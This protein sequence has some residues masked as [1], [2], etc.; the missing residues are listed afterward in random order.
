MI[1]VNLRPGGKK[2]SPRG[3]RLAISFPKFEK[4]PQDPWVLA[5]IASGVAVV[6]IAAWLFLSLGG[7]RD[8]VQVA[9]DQALADSARYHEQ[10]ERT[11]TLMASRDSIVQR[12]AIIQEIDKGRYVWP[13]VVDEVSRALPD[14]TWI[15]ELAQITGGPEP[16]VRIL[17][18]SG[19]I[20]AFSVFMDQLEASPFLRNVTT[21]GTTEVREQN[22]L[23]FRYELEVTYEQPPIE[24]LQ[25]EPLLTT[26]GS[27]PLPADGADAPS[28]ATD[29]LQT[30]PGA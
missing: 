24:F 4:L 29:T 3:K 21:L 5:A 15:L 16:R 1:E 13:H 20:E 22:Q 14:Y 10:I 6:A 30:P 7:R 12:V 27:E 23:V 28:A 11:N 17:G 9:L 2:R 19:S 18:R 8:E 25:T 26:A